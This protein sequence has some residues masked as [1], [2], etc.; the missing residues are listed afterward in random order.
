MLAVAASQ[1]KINIKALAWTIG[2]HL[3]LLLF[4]YL[5]HY[6]LPDAVAPPVASSGLEINLGTSPD[7]SGAD[8]PQSRQDPSEYTSAVV[9]NTAA[10]KADLPKELMSDHSADAPVVNNTPDKPAKA[11]G[12]QPGKDKPRPAEQQPRYV[13]QGGTGKGGNSAQQ[14]QPGKNEG[15]TTG[16]GDRGVPG[17]T[18]GANNYTG[19]A[20]SGGIGHTLTGREI[21]PKRLEAEFKEGGTVVIHVTVDRDGN[22]VD[23]YVKSSSNKELT[24]LAL[25]KLSK[26]RFSKSNSTE[27]QQFGDV[28]I[29]FKTR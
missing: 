11:V 9:F 5:L 25:E 3:L 29:V 17:G 21:T 20:G 2:L 6:T 24:R 23:K 4:F 19:A 1:S 22:I 28:T 15:N 26:A 16:P 12:D 27:P 14:D 13:Y 7:G 18:P 8:Q 10:E